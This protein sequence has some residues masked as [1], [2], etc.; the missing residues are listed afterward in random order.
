MPGDAGRS[1]SAVGWSG[2]IALGVA[3][4]LTGVGVSS[5]FA[6]EAADWSEAAL[7][8]RQIAFA[9][10]G[11]VAAICIAR[12]GHTRIGEWSYVLYGLILLLLVLLVVA[13]RVPLDP[14]FPVRRNTARWIQLGPLQAQP[15]EYAKIVVVLALARYLRFRS[16]YRTVGGLIAPFL[17][18]LVPTALILKEPDLGT[19][20][21]FPPVLLIMLYAA[22]ARRRHLACVLGAAAVAAPLFYFSPLMDDYQRQR[23]EVL[24]RQNDSDR[25]WQMGP[26]FQLRQSKIAIGSGRWTGQDQEDTAFFRHN[27]LP[28]DQNDFIF[29]VI[30]HQGGFIGASLIVF[31]Y[32][33]LFAAG[34]TAASGTDEPYAR[35]VGVGLSG[36]LVMQALVNMG[37]TV[38]LMPITGVTLP[39]VSSG[40][41][42]LVA[43]YLSI[44]LLISVARRQPIRIAR[45]PFEYSVTDAATT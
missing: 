34:L 17:L 39:F 13:R 16:N 11:L 18:T 35:L 8:Q 10:T 27:L 30:G 40:G 23:I 15:S 26:G 22:G 24:V 37:M 19:A 36:I 6:G 4:L 3:L 29:A 38:G 2:W 44:G 25:R 42:S 41:S 45:K 12:I 1:R 9:A 20:L 28:E 43:N 31:A 32:V 33:V 21:L 14:I 5:I 7:T